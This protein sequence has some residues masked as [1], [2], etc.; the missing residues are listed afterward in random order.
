ML[1][2][3]YTSNYERCSKIYNATAQFDSDVFGHKL[4]AYSFYVPDMLHNGHDPEPDSDYVHQS[5]TSGLWFNAFLDMYLDDLRDQG[6]LVVATFDEVT[7]QNDDDSDPNNNNSIATILFGSGI[8]ANTQDDSYITHYGVLRG[9]ISNFDL[10]S[11]GRND[12]NSTN[13]NL[14]SILS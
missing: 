2:S 6:T 12:T 10:G 4:P 13:G 7:W 5:T 14:A 11:L 9:V 1:F 3:T 8:D